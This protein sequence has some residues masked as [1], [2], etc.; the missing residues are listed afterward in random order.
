[1]FKSGSF[2]EKEG[3]IGAIGN[4]LFILTNFLF[5]FM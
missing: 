3:W 1:M 4:F 5:S 2:D